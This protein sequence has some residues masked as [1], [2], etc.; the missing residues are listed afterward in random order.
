MMNSQANILIVD[1][2]PKLLESLQTL[3]KTQGHASTCC[4]TVREARL[5]LEQ[6]AFDLVLL[7]IRVGQE[8]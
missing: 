2:D 4:L 8:I 5:C 7:D 6:Q 3:L 1:D